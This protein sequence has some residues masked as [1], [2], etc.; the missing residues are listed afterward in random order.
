MGHLYAGMRATWGAPTKQPPT[1]P[2]PSSD[3]VDDPD[4]VLEDR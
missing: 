4:G 1:T 3:P 2:A